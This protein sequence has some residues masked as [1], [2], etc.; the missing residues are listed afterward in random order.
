MPRCASSVAR[1]GVYV[2]QAQR[3]WLVQHILATIWTYCSIFGKVE[4]RIGDGSLRVH[5]PLSRG[6]RM[7]LSEFKQ[8]QQHSESTTIRTEATITCWKFVID[9]KQSLRAHLWLLRA[10]SISIEIHS[11]DG[12]KQYRCSGEFDHAAACMG[13]EAP[14]PIGNKKV[15][16]SVM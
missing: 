7:A 9:S 5:P 12:E 6:Y 2:P 8:T 10:L 11:N 14:A 1:Q 13:W 3:S 15:P 16:T 4:L